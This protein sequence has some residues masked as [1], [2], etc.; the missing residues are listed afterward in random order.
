MKLLAIFHLSIL[1]I[2]S[3][4]ILRN[5]LNLPTNIELADPDFNIPGPVDILIGADLVWYLLGTEKIALG[6]NIPILQS[7]DLGWII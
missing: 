5:C 4:R 6:K 7:T 1:T 3:F 2:R